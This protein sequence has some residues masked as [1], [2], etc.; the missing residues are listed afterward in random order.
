MTDKEIKKKSG[1]SIELGDDVK[2][3][4]SETFITDVQISYLS[5]NALKILYLAISQ[6]RMND[7]VFYEYEISLKELADKLNIAR[8]HAYEEIDDITSELVSARLEHV[9]GTSKKP[10]YKKYPL[11]YSCEYD[12]ETKMLKF[13]LSPN[14]SPYLLS[15]QHDFTQVLLNDFMMLRNANTILFWHLLQ[16]KIRG[17]MPM[18][19][20]YVTCTITVDE[21]KVFLG[22]NVRKDNISR[23][24]NSMVKEL[25]KNDLCRL[26]YTPI[27]N[28]RSISGYR[29][30]IRNF[31]EC[32]MESMKENEIFEKAYLMRKKN[33][34]TITEQEEIRYAELMEKYHKS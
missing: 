6:C 16:T 22:E 4:T 25:E 23:A 29:F 14:L 26:E 19:G 18:I 20:D 33:K 12:S 1:R 7:D 2:V 8:N 27:K 30:V 21:L 32:N 11:F 17:K 31:I 15:L 24:L 5:V 28:G 3:V 13:K 34:G 10:S 9:I